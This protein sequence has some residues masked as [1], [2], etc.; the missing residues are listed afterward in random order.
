MDTKLSS[1]TSLHLIWFI[2]NYL[3]S[4]PLFLSSFTATCTSLPAVSRC[5]RT[6]ASALNPA[7][8]VKGD[9]WGWGRRAAQSRAVSS[10]RSQR[11]V[12]LLR[13]EQLSC[14]VK[15]NDEQTQC[16]DFKKVTQPQHFFAPLRALFANLLLAVQRR[17]DCR[18]DMNVLSLP[19]SH[20][21]CNPQY[22]EA[23]RNNNPITKVKPLLGNSQ[24]H[25]AVRT[26][27][28]E[29]TVKEGKESENAL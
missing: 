18:R 5:V 3:Q 22:V 24:H 4:L 25:L 16:L 11:L 14:S 10:L 26:A 6:C 2:A 29:H 15:Q 21:T 8:H 19:M 27:D 20:K 1:H 17:H 12:N 9:W 13:V 7:G 28:S 23:L